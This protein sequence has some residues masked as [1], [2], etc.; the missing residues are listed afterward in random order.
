MRVLHARVIVSTRFVP[1]LVGRVRNLY[2]A[3]IIP[4]LENSLNKH[5]FGFVAPIH[6]H[7]VKSLIRGILTQAKS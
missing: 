1:I 6:F 7:L 4:I 2:N 5:L 3:R